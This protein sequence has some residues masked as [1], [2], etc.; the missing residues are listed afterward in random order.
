[1]T[2]RFGWLLAL[3]WTIVIALGAGWNVYEIYKN[4]KEQAGI[5][6]L[7][8][9]EK[10]VL[11]RSW[12]AGH[13]GVY[14]PITDETPPNPY[15]SHLKDRDV[16]TRS[17]L[18]LTLVNPAYMTRQVFELGENKYGSKSHIT[19]LRPIR[20][21]NAPDE[22]ENEALKMFERGEIEAVKIN[23]IDSE[24]YL[25]F[26]RPL[27]TEK[28]CL[29]CHAKQGY[30]EGDVRGG[31]SVSIPMEPFYKLMYNNISSSVIGYGFIW[32]LGLGGIFFSSI[33]ILRRTYEREKAEKEV[34]IL[35]EGLEITVAEKTKDLKEKISD[36]QRLY[37]ATVDREFRVKAL[38]DENVKLKAELKKKG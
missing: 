21:E 2:K 7:S 3:V 22:W 16:T 15:L 6:A 1:M 19:S 36:L 37:D 12:A 27:I 8:S 35:K 23:E 5:Q 17:G 18:K 25:R 28:S 26:M 34:L 24:T 33:R 13:G 32:I 31:I 38:S 10:D 9:F 29:K 30:K 11:Y 4:T 14:V 20:P